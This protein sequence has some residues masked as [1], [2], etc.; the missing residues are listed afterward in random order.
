[1]HGF[2][3]REMTGVNYCKCTHVHMVNGHYSNTFSSIS[4]N[5]F[6]SKVSIKKLASSFFCTNIVLCYLYKNYALKC[7]LEF[8]SFSFY[9]A[10]DTLS[11]KKKLSGYHH[12]VGLHH[13]LIPFTVLHIEKLVFPQFPRTVTPKLHPFYTRKKNVINAVIIDLM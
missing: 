12:I 2:K 3:Y 4:V 7:S 6:N 5:I 9:F 1:M 13:S 10:T 11:R 8:Q